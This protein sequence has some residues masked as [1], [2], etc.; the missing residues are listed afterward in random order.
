MLKTILVSLVLLFV[1]MCLAGG[2]LGAFGGLIGS[3]V[4]LVTGLIG[5]AVGLVAGILGALV[6]VAA[7]L[8]GALLPVIFFVVIVAGIVQLIKLI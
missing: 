2:T 8:V 7:G 3:L 6:G 5:A 1:V 4:G